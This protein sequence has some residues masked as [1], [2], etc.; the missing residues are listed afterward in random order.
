MNQEDCVEPFK[1]MIGEAL[2]LGMKLS[3]N[4]CRGLLL[5]AE[6]SHI[7]TAIERLHQ[8]TREFLVASSLKNVTAEQVFPLYEE[9][10]LLIQGQD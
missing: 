2:F 3:D 4:S 5:D 6:N 7:L 10:Q 9:I 1:Q 8:S